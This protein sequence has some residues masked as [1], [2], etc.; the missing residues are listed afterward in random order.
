MATGR[1]PQR[2]PVADSG[3]CCGGAGVSG[4]AVGRGVHQ[5]CTADAPGTSSAAGARVARPKKA[6]L[7]RS[8]VRVR[9]AQRAMSLRAPGLELPTYDAWVLLKMNPRNLKQRLSSPALAA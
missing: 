2:P 7:E 4:P 8:R 6:V 3:D 1:S 5:Q 9:E